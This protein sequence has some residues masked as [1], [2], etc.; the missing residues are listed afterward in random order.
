VAE[1]EEQEQRDRRLVE[2]FGLDRDVTASDP[3]RERDR[4]AERHN[5]EQF[6][7]EEQATQ[8]WYR[9]NRP[10]HYDNS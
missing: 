7:D 9:A 8:N 6:N 2:L 4:E 10:P 5:G 1:Q 3:D